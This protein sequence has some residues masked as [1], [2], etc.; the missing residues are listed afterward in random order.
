[1]RFATILLLAVTT[2][3][4]QTIQGFRPGAEYQIPR[5]PRRDPW[6][7]PDQVISA[8]SLTAT[9]TVAVIE[10]GYPYFAQRIAPLVKRVYAVNGD[11]R[12]FQGRGTLPLEI[13]PIV[14]STDAPG[15]AAASV[16]LVLMVDMLRWVPRRPLYFLAILAG[17]KPGGRLVI[18]D[19][20]LPASFP[21]QQQIT[22]L[23]LKREMSLAGLS[24]SQEL[25]FLPYQYFLVFQR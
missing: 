8:L 12:A 7:M 14:A 6:Q 1:M 24:F 25:T 11:S 15:I 13:S 10:N 2:L 21:A 17:L 9:Q 20:K 16:D 19:R 4:A 22:D 3:P 5:D 23:G 18:V